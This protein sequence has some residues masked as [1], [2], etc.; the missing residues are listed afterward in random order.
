MSESHYEVTINGRVLR[1]SRAEV[2]A[3]A[4]SVAAGPSADLAEQ[5]RAS[6]QDTSLVAEGPAQTVVPDDLSPPRGA[7]Q[8]DGQG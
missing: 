1:V 7:L 6:V 8:E 4:R 2:E 3:L 5:I